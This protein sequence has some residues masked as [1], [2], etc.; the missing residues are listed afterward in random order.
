L[1]EELGI[2]K[3]TNAFTDIS[4]T[5]KWTQQDY[6][7]YAGAFI[8]KEFHVIPTESDHHFCMIEGELEN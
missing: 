1:Q 7:L 3:Y 6:C 2:G 8:L 5:S 4:T